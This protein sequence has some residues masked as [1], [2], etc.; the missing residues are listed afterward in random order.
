MLSENLQEAVRKSG[1]T[2]ESL[3]DLVQRTGL[4]KSWFYRQTMLTGP[5]SL[6]RLKLG[7][8]LRFIP[9]EVDRWLAEQGEIK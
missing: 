4:K 5:G 1:R 2:Y 8:Y 9:E 7:K 6:P 3:D